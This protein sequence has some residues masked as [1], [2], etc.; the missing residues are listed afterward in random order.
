MDV[1]VA[2]SFAQ[3]SVDEVSEY[4]KTKLDIPEMLCKAFEG[5]SIVVP[6]MSEWKGVAEAQGPP[7]MFACPSPI[8]LLTVVLLR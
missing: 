6:Y 5:N 8:I 1:Q 4:L 2:F 7:S 3:K